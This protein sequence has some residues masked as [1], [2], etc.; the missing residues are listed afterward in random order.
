[1]VYEDNDSEDLTASEVKMCLVAANSVSAN[2]KQLLWKNAEAITGHTPT[3]SGGNT[4]SNKK[5]KKQQQKV[6]ERKGSSKSKSGGRSSSSSSSSNS[7]KKKRKAETEAE[8]EEESE[9]NDASR[10]ATNKN[11][12]GKVRGLASSEGVLVLQ[13]PVD[14]YDNYV[15]KTFFGF[16]V[17]Y[18]LLVSCQLPFYKVSMD[19][20]D[21]ME[22]TLKAVNRCSDISQFRRHNYVLNL[23]SPD[24][25]PSRCYIRMVIQKSSVAKKR[26]PT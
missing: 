22:R 17:F 10:V 26:L 6:I 21:M 24:P 11:K 15:S 1:M 2:I 13:E 4:A 8:A 20:E 25:L 9:V 18:G 23:V 5:Q 12:K 14:S 19:G 16:G 7:G 3:P